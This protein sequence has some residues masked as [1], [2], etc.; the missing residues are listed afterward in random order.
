MVAG[1][2]RDGR[3][4]QKRNRGWEAE[5]VIV[6]EAEMNAQISLSFS[7]VSCDGGE[8]INPQHP[9]NMSHI[10]QGF[11]ILCWLIIFNESSKFIVT[12]EQLYLCLLLN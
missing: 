9:D 8:P 4:T 5:Q 1:D 6:S 7:G 11:N 12:A 10:H 3:E 2:T